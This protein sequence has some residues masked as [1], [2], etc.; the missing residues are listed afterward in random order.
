MEW[1]NMEI[2]KMRGKRQKNNQEKNE[3]KYRK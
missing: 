3:E 1:K 2:I